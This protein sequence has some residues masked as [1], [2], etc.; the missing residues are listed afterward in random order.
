MAK[1]D[2]KQVDREVRRLDTWTAEAL[3][4]LFG[5]ESA[6][7]REFCDAIKEGGMVSLGVENG[8]V[9]TVPGEFFVDWVWELLANA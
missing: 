1:D 6:D 7:P 4:D 8:E 5:D 2:K 9:S 3:V